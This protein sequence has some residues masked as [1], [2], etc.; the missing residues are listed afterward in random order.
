M[1]IDGNDHVQPI[2]GNRAWIPRAFQAPAFAELFGKPA[3]DWTRDEARAMAARVF[4]C[5]QAAAKD[6]RIEVRDALYGARRYLLSNLTGV[7]SVAERQRQAEARMAE[8]AAEQEQHQA[9]LARQQQ[10]RREREAAARQAAR[11]REVEQREALQAER[12]RPARPTS[13][14]APGPQAAPARTAAAVTSPSPETIVA[15]YRAKIAA[16]E[17][18]PESL[19]FLD[20]WER[21]IRAKVATTAGEVETGELL[22][23]AAEKRQ[24]I[25]DTIVTS[26]K[27]E[28]DAAESRTD[29]DRQALDR[30]ERIA[31]NIAG[32]GVTPEQL[33]EVRGYARERQIP[34]AERELAAAIEKLDGY[35][36]TL[37]GLD[38]L[39]RAVH[40]T[41]TGVLS[42]ADEPA[43]DAYLDAARTRLDEIAEAVL[44][45]F[46]AVV[47]GLPQDSIGLHTT[48]KT[49]AAEPGFQ[50]VDADLRARYE[51]V[52]AQRR[53]EI[54]AAMGTRAD[55]ARERAVAAGG[56][57]DLVGHRFVDRAKGWQLQ[58][59][60]ERQ[61]ILQSPTSATAAPYEIRGDQVVVKGPQLSLPLT[62]SGGGDTMRLEG[63]GFVFVR[64]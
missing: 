59:R 46:E 9:R 30:I 10:A 31:A 3:L 11:Q 36:Q 32:A 21:D 52:L 34:L 14:P 8:R 23:E 51:A 6:R 44:P 2:E 39:Q 33:A 64:E 43:M 29:T 35:P 13:Q 49:F 25:R 50:Q 1:A 45:D 54:R 38:N 63:L 16:L 61:A 7:L 62:R 57:P 5:G 56:D 26:A 37:K 40:T 15:D 58:F 17:A 4:E 27:R 47:A 24:M 20:R 60:D 18:L 55:A 28:I 19:R 41:R 22:R 53:Q 48:E 12:A 42:R